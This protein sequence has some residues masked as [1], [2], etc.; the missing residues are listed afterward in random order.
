MSQPGD[1]MIGVMLDLSTDKINEIVTFNERP[2]KISC[3]EYSYVF[4]DSYHSLQALLFAAEEINQN[5]NILP[6]ISLGFQVYKTCNVPYYEVQGALKF[7]AE[8]VNADPNPQ[9]NSSLS[10]SA[11][12]ASSIS[13]NSV[14]LANILGVF[15][16]PQISPFSSLALLSDRTRFPS[17]FR[18]MTSDTFQS[19]GIAQLILHFG[20]TWVGLIAP[21]DDYGLQGVQTIK[22]EIMKGGSCVA[23]TEYI[24]PNQPDLN[25]LTII[26]S[27]KKSRVK[28]I[29]VFSLGGL[30]APILNEMLKQNLTG[31]MF[32][33]NADWSRSNL[34]STAHYFPVL[35]GTLGFASKNYVVPGLSDFLDKNHPSLPTHDPW[36]KSYWEIIFNCKFGSNNNL[37]DSP[38][39]SKV[40]CT[41]EENLES[42]RGSPAYI[43]SLKYIGNNYPIVYVLAKAL[44]DL[45]TC[46][47]GKGPFSQGSCATIWNFKPWQLTHYIKKMKIT[48][49]YG[50]DI[51]FD[52]NG[53]PPAIYSILNWQMSPG[54]SVQQVDVGSF[55]TSVSQS[56]IVNSSQVFW[57]SGEQ[58][59]PRSVCSAS[60][61]IGFRRAPIQGQPSCCFECVPCLQGEISNQT[62]STNCF[63]CPW[64]QWPND[65]KSGCVPKSMEF[66][67]YGDALGAILAIFSI[68]SAFIPAFIFML[69]ISNNHTPIVKAN[70]YSLSCLLLISLC[71]CFLCSLGFIGYPELE[72]CLLRQVS[73]GLF[74]TLCVACILAKTIMVVLAFM[75]TKPGSGLR[76]WSLL[77][78]SYAIILVCFLL[79]LILSIFWLV[80]SPPFSQYNIETKP[81]II[82]VN[83]NEGSPEAFWTMLGYL[84]LLASISF[85]VAFLARRLPDS[86]NE[87]QFITFSMLAFLCVWVSYIP[88]SL[89]AQGKYTVAMEIFAIL[90]STWALV[91]CIFLPKCYIILLRPEINTKEYLMKKESRKP[92]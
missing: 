69:F 61:S 46:S 57:P 7:L 27:I 47:V 1:I 84:F 44:D 62:D 5:P 17:F 92:V 22:E 72:K 45:K 83:C 77:R 11:V 6:N 2:P 29:V 3:T 39:V 74:F 53:D 88:A 31:K 33:A 59:V 10:F 43:N 85:I 32:I 56:L 35:S 58:E 21:E 54:G 68:I 81:G 73:F 38:G 55:S 82:I 76:K 64:D 52:D 14:S 78:V 18:T 86:F 67:S 49:S 15:R 63:R 70:N 60:C 50:E 40:P 41:G 79:Q 91:L 23:F 19:K 16:Y 90:T 36:V 9:C 87:A 4:L 30:F 20:W 26:N 12:I 89:S 28:V 48:L 42:V 71:L 51:Y 24:L 66:L 13:S 25:V 37:T 65:Q 75:A 8:P 34:L 80:L